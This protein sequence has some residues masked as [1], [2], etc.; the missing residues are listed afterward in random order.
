MRCLRASPRAAE[1]V[2]LTTSIAAATGRDKHTVAEA[3]H[4]D[5]RECK[6]GARI[7]RYPELA[8]AGQ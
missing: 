8:G 2:P 4:P 5:E 1:C 3:I 7:G 6:V